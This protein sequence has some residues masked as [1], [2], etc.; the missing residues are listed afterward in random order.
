MQ[1]FMQFYC[2]LLWCL[3]PW[4]I[5]EPPE[6]EIPV[7]VSKEDCQRMVRQQ[8]FQTPN[9]KTHPVQ[10]GPVNVFHSEDVGTIPANAAGVSCQGQPHKIR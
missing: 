4:K 1:H 5:A 8:I 10:L 9:G 7:S 6:V 2:E 3:F